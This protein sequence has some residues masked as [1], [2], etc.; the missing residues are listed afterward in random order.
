MVKF[1]FY[2]YGNIHFHDYSA[3][4]VLP[5]LYVSASQPFL[6]QGTSLKMLAPHFWTT[7]K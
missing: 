2:I 1:T 4:S 3:M 7:E 6:T 5:I